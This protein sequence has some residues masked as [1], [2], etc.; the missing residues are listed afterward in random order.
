MFN[1]GGDAHDG[2][3]AGSAANVSPRQECKTRFDAAAAHHVG[4]DGGSQVVKP[5]HVLVQRLD[6]RAA[7]GTAVAASVPVVVVEQ[8]DGGGGGG[9]RTGVVRVVV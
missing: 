9:R 8:G 6:L 4:L 7:S 5:V 2:G 1:C 3:H